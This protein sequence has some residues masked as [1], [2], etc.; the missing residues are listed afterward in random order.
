MIKTYSI[1][2]VSIEKQIVSME[3]DVSR[4]FSTELE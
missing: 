1:V 4:V 3:I 2:D